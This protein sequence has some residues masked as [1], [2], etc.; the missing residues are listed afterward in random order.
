MKKKQKAGPITTTTSNVYLTGGNVTFSN[1]SGYAF[2]PA[3][4][5]ESLRCSCGVRLAVTDCRLCGEP[6]CFGCFLIHYADGHAKE[7]EA[8]PVE[9][10]TQPASL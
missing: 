10:N 2:S 5:K 4:V 8:E 9:E 6:L 1:V 3:E 7:A